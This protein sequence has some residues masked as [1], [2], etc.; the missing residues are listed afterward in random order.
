MPRTPDDSQSYP[1]PNDEA[2]LKLLE[3]M[4]LEDA[5]LADAA[6]RLWYYLI[7]EIKSGPEGATRARQSLE[8]AL[9][10]TFQFTEAHKACR[11]LFE[12]SVAGQF[13][14]E[15][16]PLKALGAAIERR[17]SPVEAGRSRR[18]KKN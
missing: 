3:P 6:G 17:K 5:S 7:E 16:D 9:R 13:S 8:D 2:W 15:D 10:L 11:T 4:L 18:K 1:W 12:M 14:P